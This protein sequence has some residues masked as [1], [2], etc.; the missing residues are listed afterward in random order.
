M[1]F[2]WGMAFKN[3]IC[4]KTTQIYFSFLCEALAKLRAKRLTGVVAS[5]EKFFVETSMV[6][7]SSESSSDNTDLMTTYLFLFLRTICLR[8]Q[9]E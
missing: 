5:F 7:C 6:I 3:G 1:L 8:V 4:M 2:Q 9:P